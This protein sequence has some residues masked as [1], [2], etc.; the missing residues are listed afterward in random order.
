MNLLH[1]PW[2]P[3]RDKAGTRYWITPDR[4]SDPAFVSFDADRPDFN[5]ALAQFAIGLLQTTTP[6][7]SP[8]AW[9]GLSK[10]PPDA[11]V[12]RQW[13]EPVA[14]AFEFDGDGARFMQDIELN[15][16]G[17]KN[18]SS[19]LIESPG[20]STEEDNKAHFVKS[21]QVL[22]MCPACTAAA[23]LTLQVNAPSGG[24]GNRTSV[25]GGGPLT[26]LLLDQVPASLWRD[27]WLNICERRVFLSHIGDVEQTAPHATFPWL[28][29]I[30]KLQKNDVPL[31][32]AQVHPAHV[33]WAMPRRIRIDFS[34]PHTGECGIC[35]RTSND[36]IRQYA[37]K[38]HG[39]NYESGWNHPLSPYYKFK[40][41]W[42]PLHPHEDGLGYRHWLAWVLG[43]SD[44]K[45]A[46][47]SARVVDHA[48]THRDRQLGG[49][50]RLWAF[51]YDM[52]NM[53]ARCWYES[54][55]PL[56]GLAECDADAQSLVKSEVA[57]W[58]AGCELAAFYLRN[59]V[60]SAW[61]DADARGD[62][63]AISASFWDATESA[64]H[65]RLRQLI[66]TLQA[67]RPYAELPVRESLHGVL[68]DKAMTLFDGTFVGSGPI[69]RQ[70]PQRAA[71]AYRQLSANLCGPKIFAALG[72]PQP[73]SAKVGKTKKSATKKTS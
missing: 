64:F 14:A 66:E 15:D 4:L 52:D 53:K 54:T 49:T 25:R 36:L 3:V 63:S 32:P 65:T 21:G 31:M 1:H 57:R 58:L 19:L 35:G 28:A 23:L 7:D 5:G 17:R 44:E 37:A 62:F 18:V 39:I 13:F 60:K 12:L 47:R 72:L 27:I 26:T 59:A 33:F 48:I 69:E 30:S 70:K 29:S 8:I 73:E 55:V 40:D 9:R 56:Y 2:I 51:G 16:Q 24:S 10:Q 42:L 6:V 41:E 71:K 68:R 11:A 45:K 61:F 43:T 20:K 67:G 22:A 38:K 34:A 46:Q 50:L